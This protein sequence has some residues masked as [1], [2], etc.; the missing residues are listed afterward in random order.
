MW[1]CG[2]LTNL[3]HFR[4]LH[5]FCFVVRFNR[6]ELESFSGFNGTVVARKTIESNLLFAYILLFRSREHELAFSISV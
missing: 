1:K 5:L 4:I 6:V 2:T 3:Q